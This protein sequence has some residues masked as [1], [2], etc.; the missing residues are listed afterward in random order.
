MTNDNDV[1]SDLLFSWSSSSSNLFD[2]YMRSQNTNKDIYLP[3]ESMSDSNLYSF[4]LKTTN[5][6]YTFSNQTLV[7]VVPNSC[8][9]I[10]DTESKKQINDVIIYS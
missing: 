8:R 3:R 2:R 4:F 10:G 7:S 6:M 5:P 1:Y 9:Y